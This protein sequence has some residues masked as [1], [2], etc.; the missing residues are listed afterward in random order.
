M[1]DIDDLLADFDSEFGDMPSVMKRAAVPA[2]PSSSSPSSS[3]SSTSASSFAPKSQPQPLSSSSY[4]SSYTSSTF[5]SLNSKVAHAPSSAFSAKTPAPPQASA[6]ASASVSR[7]SA[8]EGNKSGNA[9][10]DLLSSLDQEADDASNLRQST[11]IQVKGVKSSV[12][13]CYPVFLV[14]S[15]DKDKLCANLRCTVCDHSVVRLKGCR[16]DRS[17]DYLF[18][19][20]A[21]L[22]LAQL[23]TRTVPS[24]SGRDAAFCCQCMWISIDTSVN[25]SKVVGRDKECHD[26]EAKVTELR[27]SCCGH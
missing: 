22:N 6:S 15:T 3:S 20:N 25:L 12:H 4:S 19:R 1:S 27:W 13:S 24:A 14:D 8:T 21:C 17:A 10:D 11:S 7:G 9:F 23:K 16:W 18:F 2:K 26:R 5:A